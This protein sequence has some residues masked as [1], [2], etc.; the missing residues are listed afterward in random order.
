MN[1]DEKHGS[2]SEEI[3]NFDLNE[4]CFDES[5]ISSFLW[6]MMSQVHQPFLERKIL[7]GNNREKYFIYI[8]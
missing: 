6:K 2:T 3:Y 7:K 8:F 1:F 5:T 4:S